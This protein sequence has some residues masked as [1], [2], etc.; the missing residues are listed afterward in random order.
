MTIL[1]LVSSL[2][3]TCVPTPDQ[4]STP[5]PVKIL[6]LQRFQDIAIFIVALYGSV[7]PVRPVT[8]NIPFYD[9]SLQT[10]LNLELIAK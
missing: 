6:I 2:S 5:P 3:F 9:V 8:N 10:A 4:P 7:W 1:K